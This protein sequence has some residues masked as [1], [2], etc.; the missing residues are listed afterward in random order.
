MELLRRILVRF[1]I[2]QKAAFAV[3]CVLALVGV[4][5]LLL[6]RAARGDQTLIVLAFFG[7]ALIG[8][9]F[10]GLIMALMA[11]RR[12]RRLVQALDAIAHGHLDERLPPAPDS[13][14]VAVQQ[15]F[16][17]MGEA[18]AEARTKL[19]HADTQRR[20]LFAD[21]AHELATPASAMLGLVDTL[22][23]PK[24]CPTEADRAR[25]LTALD[26]E[27]TRLARLVADVRDLATLDE[28]DVRVEREPTDLA[29]LARRV[30]ERPPFAGRVE[31]VGKD[32]RVSADPLRL[33][34]VLVNLL[35]NALRYTAEGAIRVEVATV[36]DRARMT[37]EDAG[38]GVP[39]EQ[40]ARLGERL[41][42]VDPSRDRRT[43][44]H[45]LG[46][47]IVRAIVE[48]HDG[49]LVFARAELGGLAARIELPLA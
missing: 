14:F 40:L 32:V 36:G 49:T 18:L 43:G 33:E 22:N 9:T 29:A 4:G 41:F 1:S 30:V 27:A 16:N 35:K 31:V 5:Q 2:A 21:L 12:A 10:A 23:D 15:A 17:T 45:G 42:R 26:G 3:A 7:P 24:L 47:A 37:V 13:E 8:S 25:L 11:R 19:E 44:G 39:D 48:K 46:L 34:Q 20:R 28:P 6:V 38:P